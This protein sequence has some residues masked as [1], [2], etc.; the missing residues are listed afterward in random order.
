M[1]TLKEKL[2]AIQ[3]DGPE[4]IPWIVKLL[5]NPQSPLALPGKISLENHDCLHAL[6][7]R[8]MSLDDEAFLVGFCMGNA[9]QTN[10]VHI[11]IFKFFSRYLY[12]LKYRFNQNNF[13]Y[14]NLGFRYGRTFKVQFNSINFSNYYSISLPVLRQRFGFDFPSLTPLNPKEFS[15]SSSKMPRKK[16]SQ[17]W[18]NFF[19]IS[20]SIFGLI[21]GVTLAFN[22][23]ISG[24]GF[25]FLACSSSQML[26]AS[27]LDKDKLLIFYSSTIFICVDSFGIYRWLL[28]S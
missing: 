5:E 15:P 18:N 7:E 22:S 9:P 28:S 17:Y 26:I 6:L 25:I 4:D 12:P 21:G 16:K 3:V 1:V 10:F 19:K 11:G 8:G 14:F 27:I 20:S 13:A 2:R 23:V 24:Y